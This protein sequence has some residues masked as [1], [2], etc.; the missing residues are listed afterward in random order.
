MV[1]T[2][3]GTDI[4][5]MTSDEFKEYMDSRFDQLM[6]N[7]ATKD[8]L[9]SLRRDFSSLLAKLEQQEAT[10]GS[11]ATVIS[12]QANR[13]QILEAK[14]EVLCSHVEHILAAQENQE[15]YS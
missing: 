1:Q 4:M 9:N 10:I 15:Q 5:A 12:E 11:S 3:G 8:D 6:A 13:I 7:L 14:N 2:Q